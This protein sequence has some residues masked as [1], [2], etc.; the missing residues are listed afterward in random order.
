MKNSPLL[1]SLGEPNSIF[2]EI[3]FKTLK[4][5]TIKKFNR[6]ILVIGSVNLLKSQMKSLKYSFKIKEVNFIKKKK[7]KFE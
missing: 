4:K 3:L 6:P 5:K 1:I 7:I 2:S